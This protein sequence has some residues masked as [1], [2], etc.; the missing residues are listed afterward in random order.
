MKRITVYCVEQAIWGQTNASK[1]FFRDKANA[2]AYAMENEYTSNA[3]AV[4]I[5]AKDA[6]QM[7]FCDN[8]VEWG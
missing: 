4:R 7:T 8:G 5:S 1:L 6:E 3:Y 2:Y